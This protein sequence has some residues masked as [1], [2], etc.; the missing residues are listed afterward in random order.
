MPGFVRVYLCRVY[1]G[2]QLLFR[3]IDRRYRPSPRS[4]FI[5]FLLLV[6]LVVRFDLRS[7]ANVL[8]IVVF[9]ISE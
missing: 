1:T 8:F 9:I 4:V 5:P 7:V 2:G 6:L 3:S